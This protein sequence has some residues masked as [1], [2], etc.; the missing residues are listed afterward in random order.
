MAAHVEDHPYDYGWFE[1][2][3]PKGNYGA[4]QVIVWDA[5]T[6][7]P[8]EK[9]GVFRGAT[10]PRAAPRMRRTWRAG[11]IAFTLRG[12]KLRGSWTLVRTARTRRTGC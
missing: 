9:G 1:G 11:K 12:K 8:D 6:Y 5:G 3:I 7:S 2:V 4:G 10:R